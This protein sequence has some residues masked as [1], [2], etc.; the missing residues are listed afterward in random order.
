MWTSLEGYNGPVFL[1]ISALSPNS[2]DSNINNNNSSN[3]GNKWIIGVLTEQGFENKDTYFGNAAYLYALDPIFHSFSPSGPFIR[4]KGTGF[5][6]IFNKI[7]I[8]S[9]TERNWGPWH[10]ACCYRGQGRS[11]LFH[12]FMGRKK[13]WNQKPI[14]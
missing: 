14:K 2:N 9:H 8:L 10:S 5:Q 4:K 1:L 3:D 11:N 6:K 7:K 13:M 12:R